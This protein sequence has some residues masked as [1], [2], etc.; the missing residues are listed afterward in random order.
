MSVC[1]LDIGFDQKIDGIRY[2]VDQV[3]WASLSSG[4]PLIWESE[5]FPEPDHVPWEI[6]LKMILEIRRYLNQAFPAL[7]EKYKFGAHGITRDD[8]GGF[9]LVDD[10]CA[11]RR[12]IRDI[13]KVLLGFVWFEI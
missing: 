6:W 10:A 3:L 11:V 13:P 9:Q 5:K 7:V 12:A 8:I 2:R 4:D 1:S